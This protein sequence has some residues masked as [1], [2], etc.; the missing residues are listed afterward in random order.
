L[1]EIANCE[2]CGKP[3]VVNAPSGLCPGCLLRTAIEHGSGRTLAP[4]LPKLRYFG[5]YELQEEIAHGGMG[6]V[7]RARQVSLDRV[8]AVKM[9]RPGLLATE[10]EIGRFQAEARTAAG[11]Q[12]PNIVAVHEVGEFEG[13]HYFSMDLVDGPSLAEL[14]R[15]RPLAPE[16]GANYV[17]ILAEAVQ[18]AHGKGILH[19]D[20]KPSN[21]LV[22]A[23]GRPRI[24]DFGLARSMESGTGMT[25]T[26]AVIGTP[27]YMPP[28]Q[29]A[30]NGQP[31]TPASDCYSLGAILFELLTGRA[32]FQATSPVAIVRM[33]L[34]QA[35]VS[36]RSIRAEVSRSLEDICMK[37]L[38]KD[39]VRRY[40]SAADLAADLRRF[41]RGEPLTVRRSPGWRWSWLPIAAL[42]MAAAFSWFVLR[43]KR[44]DK[45]AV[46]AVK[47]PVPFSTPSPVAATP[48]PA[49]AIPATRPVLRA[50][51]PVPKKVTPAS[52]SSEVFTFHFR[53]NPAA[54]ETEF[55]DPQ[56]NRV[57]RVFVYPDDGVVQ[58]QFNPERGPGLRLAGKLNSLAVLENSVCRVDLSGVIYTR[59]DHDS[60]LR[61]PVSFKADFAGS[62][63]IHSWALDSAG[64]RLPGDVETKQE[65]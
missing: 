49:A 47:E 38:E 39:P 12:H 31:L 51:K 24:T 23:D 14:V 62:K 21:V 25:I 16:E 22:D 59:T 36:P 20:L 50:A 41:L 7:Y 26:G 5:D 45:P 15:Q 40:E 34:E 42:L 35:P 3:V 43:T 6:V 8:V 13:L 61:L 28:E 48:T 53:E 18:Y 55:R 60:E 9:M 33:V 54:I 64:T 46:P 52:G 29:A 56:S 17:Q 57:C 65:P 63:E 37:C 32:P 10:G 2:D 19:R 11:M 44:V 4:L 58:L 27:A 1:P 30:G